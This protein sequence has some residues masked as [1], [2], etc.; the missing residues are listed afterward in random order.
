MATLRSSYN[1]LV[2]AD[3]L[4]E[5]GFSPRDA[6]RMALDGTSRHPIVGLLRSSY[7]T[8]ISIKDYDVVL[9][10]MQPSSDDSFRGLLSLVEG[11]SSHVDMREPWESGYRLARL[12]RRSLKLSTH[13]DL[14]IEKLI[15]SLGVAVHDVDFSDPTIR[16]VCVGA[17]AF[18]PL[19]IVNRSS[20][21]A[22]GPS[23]RRITLAHE[24]CHL[25]FDRI[26][27]A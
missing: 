17:P 27:P 9:K 18:G 14:D 4:D 8:S 6:Q 26:S 1:P 22:S 10:M 19:I 23:G 25:L 12:I 5:R 2:T 7:G 3:W 16:G 24:L 20:P 15:L 11:I 13:D 21:D